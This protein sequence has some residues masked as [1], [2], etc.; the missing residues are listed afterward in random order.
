MRGLLRGF[1]FRR[2]RLLSAGAEPFAGSSPSIRCSW[3]RSTRSWSPATD[4][5]RS[6]PAST[7]WSGSGARRCRLPPPDDG[8]PCLPRVAISY[9]A[10]IDDPA[11]FARSKAV[12]AGARPHPEPLPIRRD[13]STGRHHQG[14]RCRSAGR[15]VR[16]GA[17]DDDPYRPLVPLE[18]L[19]HA[20]G[21]HAPAPSA[22]K[23]HLHAGLLRSCTACGSTALTSRRNRHDAGYACAPFP[24]RE[25][26][27]GDDG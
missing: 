22:R 2:P 25:E 26:P 6:S 24:L 11:R 27:G 4:S 20:V 17:R 19:G 21:W 23:S 9:V 14:R 12:G 16:S 5:A 3:R 13:R 7:S 1:G 10:A 15:A 8:A 18:G